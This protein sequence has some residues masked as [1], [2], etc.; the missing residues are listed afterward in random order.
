[1]RD[2]ITKQ[3]IVL[4][5]GNKGKVKEMADVLGDFGFE[6]ISQTDLGIESRIESLLNFKTSYRC[7][8]L[9]GFFIFSEN[10]E[11]LFL[12]KNPLASL[13][14]FNTL[15]SLVGVQYAE[16]IPVNL[17]QLILT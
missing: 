12:F 8:V 7:P 6:V 16:I 1:M 2:S 11:S 9:Q 5:T 3:K 4:V 10:V 13:I 15:K 17:K 14:N